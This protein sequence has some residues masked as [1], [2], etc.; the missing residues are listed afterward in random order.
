LGYYYGNAKSLSEMNKRK[1]ITLILVLII[2]FC[3]TIIGLLFVK[4]V[5]KIKADEVISANLKIIPKV[6]LLLSD[7]SEYTL[8]KRNDNKKLI[9]IYFNTSCEHCQYEAESIKLHIK[10]FEETNIVMMSSEPLSHIS[11]FS[12]SKGLDKFTN[13][14]FTKIRSED[15]STTCGT[16]AI[17][18]IFIYGADGILRKEFKGE[19]KADVIAN[20]L[21]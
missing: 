19:T 12:R 9:L 1:S 6:K 17:P 13:V 18:H 20:Y 21:Q 10:Q 16:L 8:T 3:A 7:S 11:A 15:L 4:S 5:D 2:A 14:T